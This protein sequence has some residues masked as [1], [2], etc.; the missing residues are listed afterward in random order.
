MNIVKC[1]L[2]LLFIRDV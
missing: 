1:E 2:G